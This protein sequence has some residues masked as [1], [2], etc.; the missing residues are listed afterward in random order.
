[1]KKL[2]AILLCA[3]YIIC[4]GSC[5]P[6]E[7]SMKAIE[8]KDGV[9]AIMQTS[10]GNIVLE[11]Y[12]KQTP[13]TVTNFV[14][15]AEGT[16]NATNGK[17]FYDGLKF[18]RVIADFMIQGGD[19]KGNGTGG[20]GYRFS[21]EFV[22]E[23]KHDVPGTLSMANAGAGTNGSQFFITHVPTPWLDGK[24]TVFG[25]VVEGQDVVN[26]IKQ[27]DLIEKVTIVRQ[28]ADA[29]AF[30]ASQD[31]FDERSAAAKKAAVEKKEKGRAATIALIEKNFPGARKTADGIYY[32]VTKEGS[33]SK[34][35]KGKAVSVHY[36]GYLLDGSVFDSSEGRGTLDFSTAAGQMIP[37]FDTMVQDM[38]TGEK[39]TI[40]LPPE[41]AYGS[42]G[43]AG[44]I[45]GDAYIAFDVELVRVK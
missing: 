45:P 2:S 37:G 10:R 3:G 12:Y 27:G 8:G 15:L 26:K 1:M 42:A 5:S 39:R 36:K 33:G 9:F 38:K 23:L 7:K 18:H 29:Q 34:V 32:V 21:D 30:T 41:Q 24:H 31:D 40:V 28:G 13:L 20:P 44:V 16:L 4:A 19:P 22:D 17:P 25:R 43:A 11:L 14:G 6:M 35:G